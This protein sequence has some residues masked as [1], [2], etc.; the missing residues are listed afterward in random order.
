MVRT[1]AR[2]DQGRRTMVK[3]QVLYGRPKDPA[4]I[5]ELDE[6]IKTHQPPK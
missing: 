4:L 5:K 2:P 1:S 3:L 6:Y